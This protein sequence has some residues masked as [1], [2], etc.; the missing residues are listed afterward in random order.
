MYWLVLYISRHQD[1]DMLDVEV[2]NWTL[3]I[4]FIAFK[5]GFFVLLY[6]KLGPLLALIGSLWILY[7]WNHPF[8]L[9]MSKCQIVILDLVELGL[10]VEVE[11]ELKLPEVQKKLCT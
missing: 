9:L 7:Y 4:N 8:I 2:D 10:D 3:H 6:W 1:D 5:P 11:G